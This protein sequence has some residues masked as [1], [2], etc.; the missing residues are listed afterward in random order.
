LTTRS[1]FLRSHTAIT[2]CTWGFTQSTTRWSVAL[3][4]LRLLQSP[5]FRKARDLGV[6]YVTA[7]GVSIISV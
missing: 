7:V 5:L 1:N 6:N 4:W 2:N 3:K